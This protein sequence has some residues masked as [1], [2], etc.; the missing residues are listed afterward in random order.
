MMQF[1]CLIV[2]AWL[3]SVTP[4]RGQTEAV[5]QA[6]SEES[7]DAQAAAKP[8]DSEES[9]DPEDEPLQ[10]EAESL[11]YE[12]DSDTVTATGDVVV[13]KGD[14]KVTA[15]SISV[16]RTTNA[17]DARGNVVVHNPEG[18]IEAEAL[19]FEMEEEIGLISDGTVRLPRHQYTITGKKLQKSYGQTYHVEE[20]TV[21]TCECDDPKKADWSIGTKT[22]DLTKRGKGVVRG[23]LL[24][25]R[26]VP[27]LYLPYVSFPVQTDRQS[28]FLS[29][30]YGFSSKRGFQW[31]QPFY[32]AINK[33]HDV[34]VTGNV[35]TAARIG[36]L[37]EYRY[38]P[39][40]NLEGHLVA[41]YF[42]E[43]IRGPAST[44]S[45]TNRWS[46]TGTHRQKL[47]H[48]VRLYGDF[49]FVGDDRFLREMNTPFYAGS[50]DVELRSRRWTRSRAGAVKTWDRS[51][52][53]GESFYF[54]DLRNDDTYAFQVLP[55]I[56]FQTAHHIWKDRLEVGADVQGANF[57]REKGYYGQRLNISPWISL[58]FSLGGYV[59]GSLKA[60]AH[61][62]LYHMSSEEQVFPENLGRQKPDT[63]FDRFEPNGTRSRETFE[64]KAEIGTRLT[65][66]FQ[67]NWGSLKKLKHVAEP[68]VSYTYVP[69][70]NQDDLPLFDG[71]DRMNSRSL[72]GYGVTNRLMGKFDTGT[73]ET[74]EGAATTSVRELARLTVMQAYDPSRRLR[75]G[76]E[77]FGISET[78]QH[79]SDVA[80][81]AR[82]TP[83]PFLRLT[84]DTIYDIDQA[85][86]TATRVGAYLTDPR[87]LPETSPLFQQLQRRT[88][89]GVSYR[90]ISDRLL[91]E[92]NANLI[93]RLNE[94]F[95][96]AYFSRYDLNDNSF[97]GN[98]YYLRFLSSQRCWA[99]D[100]GIVDK[101][102]P[103]ETEFRFAVTLIGIS[104]FGRQAF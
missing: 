60:T 89:L 23:G 73:A 78:R 17:V 48:D 52:L 51:L 28:G 42:N 59:Y 1:G 83:F 46:L 37:G 13:I 74:A 53:R 38:A 54:Q 71:L 29:P 69:V 56:Q 98:R 86:I 72:F 11:S 97:I 2:I 19:Q 44:S 63:T 6:A 94:Y 68:H 9:R 7:A 26:D 103:S 90:T 84:S 34:T 91:K 15:D 16:N 39:N 99:F 14:T 8:Q 3:L 55:T 35:E 93:V 87:P 82:L 50:G 47:P 49:F 65:R 67:V 81:D 79:F 12:E 30:G 88:T 21:T 102:N 22:L 58:P 76:A 70:V 43:K 77:R 45:P 85:E 10:V 31:Q 57:F 32:W 36:L 24:K 75:E 92:L 20:G 64:I 40:R 27:I 33:S 100:L 5:R 61:E 95:S 62:T 104:S 66:V 18:T 101:V 25:V 4:V 80:I 96:A 41:S